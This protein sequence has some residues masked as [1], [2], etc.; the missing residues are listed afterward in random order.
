MNPALSSAS[1]SPFCNTF[2]SV[3]QTCSMGLRSGEYAG[4][5]TSVHPK[6]SARA[7]SSGDLWKAA[8]SS[9]IT[10]PLGID[11]S[12]ISAKYAKTMPPSQYPSKTTGHTSFPS[13]EAEMTLVRPRL[14]P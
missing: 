14:P 11:G 1:P 12:S 9:T 5:N 7:S 13:R 6:D 4:R 8:L 3:A 2:L 10:L